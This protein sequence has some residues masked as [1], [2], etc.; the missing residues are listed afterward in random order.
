MP[1]KTFAL[2]RLKLW[3]PALFV[4]ILISTF[5]THYFSDEQTGR[6]LLP[7][8]HWLFPWATQ[9]TLH[10]MH[11]GIRKLAHITEFGVFSATVFRGV[12]GEQ[13]GWR[14]N[15]AV[16]TLLIAAGYAA[17]D[18]LH[19]SI[20]P[21]RHATPRDVAIDTFGALLAQVIVWWYATG[22]WPFAALDR[23]QSA[24]KN[25]AA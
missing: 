9:R 14:F 2:N 3:I 15:W 25:H 19:Q 5:S 4:A 12:R 18:E 13:T 10:L 6:I 20:V 11:V 7:A 16:I 21:L 23:N 24:V 1:E 22:K 8:L 17:L